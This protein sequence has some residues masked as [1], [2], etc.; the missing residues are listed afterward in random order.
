MK[1]QIAGSGPIA[2]SPRR[3]TIRKLITAGASASFL[4]VAAP[5]HA[6]EVVCFDELLTSQAAVD[7]FNCTEVLGDVYI[8]GN[9]IVNLS[10][11]SELRSVGG[12]L[13]IN[14]RIGSRL[15][16]FRNRLGLGIRFGDL[17]GRLDNHLSDRF[18]Y[19]LNRLGL[20][21]RLSDRLRLGNFRNRIDHLCDRLGL[22]CVL[23]H[24]LGT[25][26][27]CSRSKSGW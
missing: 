11:L 25:T 12:N 10:G 23:S 27:S 22:N 4:T 14:Y 15:N 20:S 26:S 17:G 19:F 3:R 5:V 18:S 21:D 6:Q 2:D 1:G 8:Q 24:R 7:A 9:N 16:C 13:G